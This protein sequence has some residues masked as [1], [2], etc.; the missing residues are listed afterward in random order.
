MLWAACCHHIGEVILTHVWDSLGIEVAKSPEITI[1]QRYVIYNS[2]FL[3]IRR[4]Y[5][6]TP[7]FLLLQH[8]CRVPLITQYT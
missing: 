6:Y 2:C 7:K 8:M 4:L 5:Q 3:N 1:F